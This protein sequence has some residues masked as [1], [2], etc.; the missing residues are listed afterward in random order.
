MYMLQRQAKKTQVA[1][2][3]FLHVVRKHKAVNTG[4]LK[5]ISNVT[6]S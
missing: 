4:Y 6:S 3:Y 2:I 1:I 5:I